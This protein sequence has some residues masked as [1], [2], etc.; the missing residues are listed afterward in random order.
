VRPDTGDMMQPTSRHSEQIYHWGD[1][2]AGWRLVDEAGL[3]V[4]EETLEPGTGEMLHYHQRAAQ[5]F[6]MID[7]TAIMHIAK[8]TVRLDTSMALHVPP[9]TVHAITNDSRQTIRFLVIS[10]PTTRGDRHSADTA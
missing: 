1:G 6:Y 3:S 2:G 8:D 10:A 7:G 5:C 4:I 9:G